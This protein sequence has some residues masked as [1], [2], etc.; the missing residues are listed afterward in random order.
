MKV[1]H[2]VWGLTFGGIETML[3]N[4]ANAQARAGAEVRVMIVNDYWD[5]PIVS[6]FDRR[7]KLLYVHKR[8]GSGNPFFIVRMN[9]MLL[10]E[11][12]DVVHLHAKG[13]VT[14]LAG[15]GLKRI[16]CQTLHDMPSGALRREGM[17][18]RLLPMLDIT[19][20]GNVTCIDK[21]RQVFAISRAV[22]D[23][24]WEKYGVASRVVCNGIPAAEFRLRGERGAGAPLRVVQVSRLDHLK[25]GQD[26]LVEAA[27]RL[28]GR[29][30]VDFVGAGASLELLKRMAAERGLGQLVR[31][32]GKKTQEE[33]KA[34][35]ADY[36]LFVQPSRF[37][38]FGLTV[39]EG[40]AAGVPVLVSAGEGPAEVTCGDLYGWT[41]EN[42]N[43]ERLAAS[44][45]YVL[46]HYGEAL[47]KAK[48]ARRHVRETYDVSV[49]ANKYLEE[50][51]RF[52]M[53]DSE[54]SLIGGGRKR[55]I[56]LSL[57][58]EAVS[59]ERRAA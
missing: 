31:F 30:A 41:F 26:L 17:I 20:P 53:A 40:M 56:A 42:G 5:E 27:A 12:P 49:T 16:A 32:L 1:V 4:I 51:K 15:K 44:M 35:L 46:S 48:A 52:I 14:L 39:A 25:K 37:E 10:R 38:G 2:V 50:Y 47:E 28:R 3:V 34:M 22:H 45:A 19:Q 36:D 33:V 29:V 54:K 23:A 8:K 7:V 58:C 43:A 18:Y 11:K 57:A 55:G 6:S 24:L 13:F 9:R 21:V 59:G